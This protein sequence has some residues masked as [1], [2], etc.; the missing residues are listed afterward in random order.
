MARARAYV[1]GILTAAGSFTLF[2]TIY[3]AHGVYGFIGPALA[4]VLLGIVGIGAIAAALVHGQALAGLGL[5]GSLITPLLVS[6]QSPN[7]WALFGYLAIV[8][9]ANT[10]IARIRDWKFLA[11]AGF[12]RR[13]HLVPAL[14][15]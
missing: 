8:L 1:P 13:R 14:P 3:A 11:S 4:F 5:L 10:A 6:S 7:A 15:G 2:G 9:V 12:P